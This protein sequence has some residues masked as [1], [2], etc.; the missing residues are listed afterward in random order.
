M[1]SFIYNN[2]HRLKS[3]DFSRYCYKSLR[4]TYLGRSSRHFFFDQFVSRK[5]FNPFNANPTKWSNTLKQLV[6][7]SRLSL[8]DYFVGLAYKGF[9]TKTNAF[10]ALPNI[11][12]WAFLL[13]YTETVWKLSMAK[14]V[15][16]KIGTKFLSLFWPLKSVLRTMTKSTDGV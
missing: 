5:F 4:F 6:G 13:K 12:N 15:H 10:A 3:I 7:K 1:E 2:N 8:F 16:K 14:T 11:Y 9:K